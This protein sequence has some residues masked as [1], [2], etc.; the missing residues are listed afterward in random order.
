MFSYL[1]PLKVLLLN[2]NWLVKVV[3]STYITISHSYLKQN[4]IIHIC[5]HS[6]YIAG[7][8]HLAILISYVK[9]SLNF[10]PQKLNGHS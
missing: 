3:N 9:R 4:F 5:I 8:Y 2:F 1:L 10:K 6:P 7:K